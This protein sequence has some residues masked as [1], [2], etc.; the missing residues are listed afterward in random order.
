MNITFIIIDSNREYLGIAY[1]AAILKKNGETVNLIR[2]ARENVIDKIREYKTD[3]VGY[4]TTTGPHKVF[5]RIN[6]IIKQYCPEVISLFGGPHPTFF[7]EMIYDDKV[8]AICRGEA[9]QSIIQ[10]VENI[11]TGKFYHQTPGFWIRHD[12]KIYKNDLF[13]LPQ[14]LDEIPFPDRKI[15]YDADPELAKIPI[16]SVLTGRGCP[17][18][19]TYCFNSSIRKMYNITN[20]TYCRKRSVDNVIAEIESLNRKQDVKFIMFP[21]DLF[22][23][24]TDWL[25]EFAVKYRY[26][27]GV[28]FTCNV[29]PIAT[30]EETIYLLKKAGAV[31]I[32]MAVETGDVA[33]R[34]QY[35]SRRDSDEQIVNV[36]RWVKKYKLNLYTQNMIGLPGETHDSYKQTILLN[37]MIKP[38]HPE[39]TI[40]QPYPKTELGEVAKQKDMFSG[41]YDRIGYNFHE[42]SGRKDD[43]ANLINNI[44]DLFSLLVK[45]PMP[46]KLCFKLLG[47]FKHNWFIRAYYKL[48]FGWEL[49]F[50]LK[51]MTIRQIYLSLKQYSKNPNYKKMLARI[52]NVKT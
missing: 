11:K 45:L 35:L 27:I 6:H 9:D 51:R 24:R 18:S 41:D 12:N 52:E 15:F 14:N 40:Y 1:L 46:L 48:N 42:S 13:P 21:D 36:S 7:P 22:A 30:R 5:L 17:F 20:R 50:F 10:F 2:A 33:V 34:N 47:R 8:D 26:A 43:E 3:I 32:Q 37:R 28:P 44:H 4:S 39:L 49:R 29:R 38:E 23:I 25:R 16:R 19:C 31:S